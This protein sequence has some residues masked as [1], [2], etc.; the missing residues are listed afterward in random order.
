[1]D[2][3][4]PSCHHPK[5]PSQNSQFRHTESKDELAAALLPDGGDASGPNDSGDGV[6]EYELLSELTDNPGTTSVSSSCCTV[7]N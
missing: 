2:S 6:E 4:C 1:M 7:T 5:I 3:S